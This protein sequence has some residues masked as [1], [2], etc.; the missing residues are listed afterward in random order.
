MNESAVA[1]ARAVLAPIKLESELAAL[2]GQFV[3]LVPQE[4]EVTRQTLEGVFLY[5]LAELVQTMEGHMPEG[6]KHIK[7]QDAL[8]FS[9]AAGPRSPVYRAFMPY[10]L[11][12]LI[13][14]TTLFVDAMGTTHAFAAM[15]TEVR[16]PPV[17]DAGRENSKFWATLDLTP[18][19]ILLETHLVAPISLALS[20]AGFTL[21][22]LKSLNVDGV[23]TCKLNVVFKPDMTQRSP[24]DLMY[25]LRKEGGVRL[26]LK[27]GGYAPARWNIAGQIL[28]EYKLHPP[29]L[30]YY[31]DC[32]CPTKSAAGTSSAGGRGRGRGRGI[33]KARAEQ[34]KAIMARRK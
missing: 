21:I 6:A 12:K 28:D 29:C 26:P 11:A 32:F 9:V 34:F 14:G 8:E 23:S 7:L 13:T 33:G 5:A 3:S 4:T 10:P 25:V 27:A 16:L 1:E 30:R 20:D 15:L 31:R 19:Y 22:R 24:C 17:Q 18:D 2:P